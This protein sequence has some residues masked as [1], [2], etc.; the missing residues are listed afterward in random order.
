[1]S[2]PSVEDSCGGWAYA[3]QEGGAAQFARPEVLDRLSAGNRAVAPTRRGPEVRVT[4]V[5]DG[6]PRP[7]AERCVMSPRVDHVQLPGGGLARQLG[8]DPWPGSTTAYTRLLGEPAGDFGIVHSPADDGTRNWPAPCS[9]PSSTT[10]RRRTGDR[11]R[12]CGTSTWGRSSTGPAAAAAH[13]HGRAVGPAGGRDPPRHLPR[14][15]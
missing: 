13:G 15:G 5:E 9:C 6:V 12:R 10:S 3:K 7:D 8:V 2:I 14:G 11:S 4:V 1:M